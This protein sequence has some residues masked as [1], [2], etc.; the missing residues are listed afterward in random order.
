M[1]RYGL[2]PVNVDCIV[3]LGVYTDD[4]KLLLGIDGSFLSA[5]VV[6]QQSPQVRLIDECCILGARL[7]INEKSVLCRFYVN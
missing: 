1:E 2:I 6:H 4:E 7:D 3:K 5:L